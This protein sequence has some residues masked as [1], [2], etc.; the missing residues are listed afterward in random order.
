[1]AKKITLADYFAEHLDSRKVIYEVDTGVKKSFAQVYENALGIVAG[2]EL[3]QG[4]R[5]TVILPNS[6]AWVEYFIAS[7]IGGWILRQRGTSKIVKD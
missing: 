3:E 7:M 4:D 2:L 6:S 5:L 1:M